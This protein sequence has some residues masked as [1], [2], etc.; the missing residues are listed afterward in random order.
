[1][2]YVSL[3]KTVTQSLPLLLALSQS[4]S[5]ISFFYAVSS[6]TPQSV[7]YLTLSLSPYLHCLRSPLS[8]SLTSI[9]PNLSAPHHLSLGP[10]FI[11]NNLP[12]I[13]L[14][15][16]F[17]PLA[18]YLSLNLKLFIP[19]SFFNPLPSYSEDS[20]IF[21]TPHNHSL[22]VSFDLHPPHLSLAP[23]LPVTIILSVSNALMLSYAFS[24]PIHLSPSQPPSSLPHL[25]VCIPE[26]LCTG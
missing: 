21:L 16:V 10:S 8:H 20:F 2:L 12:W 6:S 26:D 13:F 17:C 15:S 4:V 18:L 22:T 3:S 25:T 14:L 11:L 5:D 1:M 9:F 24:L 7:K 23:Y 19:Y